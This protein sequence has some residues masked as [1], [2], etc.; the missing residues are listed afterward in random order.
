MTRLNK[1]LLSIIFLLVT[2]AGFYHTPTAVQY[3]KENYVEHENSNIAM[4][5]N[6]RG[7]GTGFFIAHNLL[8]TNAHVVGDKTEVKVQL[9]NNAV[10][11]GQV[12]GVDK[13]HDLALV[14]LGFSKG[15][16]LVMDLATLKRGDKVYTI[17][18]GKGTWYSARY[19]RV[20]YHYLVDIPHYGI[21]SMYVR[22]QLATMPGHS[23]SPVFNSE[24]KVVGIISL[25]GGG[26]TMFIPASYIVDLHK[27][28]L[29]FLEKLRIMKQRERERQAIENLIKKRSPSNQ[30]S[31]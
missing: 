17:G 2:G 11:D 25:G 30:G 3:I 18:F 15:E 7:H 20:L 19:G 26:E 29:Q 5:M 8:V 9:V 24:G 22:A 21:R 6:G 27:K 4:I 14:K 10:V 31:K 12:V 28:Y 1:I 13:E 23:G 16:I